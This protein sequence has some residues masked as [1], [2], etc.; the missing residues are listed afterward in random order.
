VNTAIEQMETF[1]AEVRAV[2]P[3]AADTLET[4]MY[5]VY[6]AADENPAD[7]VLW[8][9]VQWVISQTN[10]SLGERLEALRI[11][12]DHDGSPVRLRRLVGWN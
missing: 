12:S 11:L 7:Q 4:G 5:T 10:R 1:L 2:S 6:A 9:A 8:D 3:A